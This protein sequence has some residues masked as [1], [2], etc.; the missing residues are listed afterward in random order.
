MADSKPSEEEVAELVR[1][2][3][4]AAALFMRGDMGRYLELIH[5]APGYTLMMPTGG[6]PMRYEDR[7][8]SVREAAGFF[9][10]GEVALESVTVHA[11]GDTVVIAMIERQ[12]GRVGDLPERDWSLRVTHVYRR[13]DGHWLLVHRHADPL[14]QT[15]DLKRM[16][17]LIRG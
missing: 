16:G 5:H 14:V 3:E 7:A 11:W 12:R 15:I 2:T 13:A 10:G 8:D 4:Q 17:A 1:R 6:P 9:Q